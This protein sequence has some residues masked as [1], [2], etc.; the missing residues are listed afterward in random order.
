[1]RLIFIAQLQRLE[2]IHDRGIIVRDV[3]PDT[4]TMG[5]TS[6]TWGLVYVIDFGLAKLYLDPAT[7]EHIAFREGRDD[8]GSLRYGSYNRHFGRGA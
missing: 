6:E 2:A 5:R 7:G 4:F 1:M 8:P 3:K